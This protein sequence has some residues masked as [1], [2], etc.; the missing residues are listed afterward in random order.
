MM[1]VYIIHAWGENPQ[2]CWYPW[3]KQQLES[4]GAEVLIPAMPGTDK[5]QIEPWVNKLSEIVPVPDKHTVFVGHSIGCQA[6]LRYFERLP[7]GAV[8]GDVLFV[9][10]WTRLTGLSPDSQKIAEPWLT[11][12]LDWDKAKAH[13]ATFTAFFSDS[14]EWAPLSEEQVFQEKLGAATKLFTKAGHFDQQTEFPELFSAVRQSLMPDIIKQVGFGFRWDERKVWALDV[15]AED[16]DISELAWHFDIPFWSKPGGFYNLPAREVIEHRDENEQEYKRTLQADISHP[17]DIMLWRG[18]WLILDGLHRLVK[19]AI[20][21]KK[22]VRVRK[23]PES[24]TP[25]IAKDA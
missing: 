12:S 9:A 2:S 3:L 6:I 13:A 19:Q 20:E 17:I 16:M 22:M 10:P 7:E 25:Q 5:P 18:R 11:T 23:V 15:P 14:D 1:K 8:A 24:A 4:K 21:G